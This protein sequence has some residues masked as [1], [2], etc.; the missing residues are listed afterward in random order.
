MVC[1]ISWNRD[2]AGASQIMLWWVT[3]ANKVVVGFR[4]TR[5]MARQ[6]MEEPEE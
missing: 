4:V 3:G 5:G 2:S 1:E 6:G